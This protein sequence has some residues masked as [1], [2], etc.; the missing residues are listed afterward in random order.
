MRRYL[1]YLPST[2]P[3]LGVIAIVVCFLGYSQLLKGSS[4]PY[5]T[6]SILTSS[7]NHL[8]PL[9]AEEFRARLFW[10]VGSAALVLA[11]LWNIVLS[12]YVLEAV[13]RADGFRR[14]RSRIWFLIILVCSACSAVLYQ[15]P[16]SGGIGGMLLLS[17]EARTGVMVWHFTT[18]TNICTG[19]GV[20]FVIVA[21]VALLLPVRGRDESRAS[22]LRRRIELSKLGLYSAS[23][24]LAVGVFQLWA[25]YTWPASFLPRDSAGPVR[26]MGNSVTFAASVLFTGCLVVIYLP[27]AVVH[28]TWLFNHLRDESARD[29]NLDQ[30]EWLRKRGLEMSSLVFVKRAIGIFAPIVIGMIT[31]FIN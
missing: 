12:G 17:I 22:C 21:A 27:T 4:A 24:L 30:D 9:P 18:F 10:G 15:M 8:L 19:I 28:Q 7:S 3:P 11:L 16:T 29:A 14:A 20:T 1:A 6:P 13:L 23:G 26:V 25:L 5:V 2:L 31:R